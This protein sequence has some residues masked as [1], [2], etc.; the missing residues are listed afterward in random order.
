MWPAA[1]IAEGWTNAEGIGHRNDTVWRLPSHC[2]QGRALVG[3]REQSVKQFN[4]WMLMWT[5]ANMSAA[6]VG[7]LQRRRMP[8][9]TQTRWVYRTEL[10]E[11]QS[12]TRQHRVQTVNDAPPTDTANTQNKFL[13]A[14]D[15]WNATLNKRRKTIASVQGT[16]RTLPKEAC[17]LSKA[18]KGNLWQ[19][20]G[21]EGGP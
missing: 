6:M 13:C 17:E 3:T 16:A 4:V 20:T 21:A 19:T 18:N 9:S 1:S 14:S 11:R 2:V 8:N 5:K 15:T 10:T 7:R 12:F